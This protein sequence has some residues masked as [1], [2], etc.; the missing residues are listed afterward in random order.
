[1]AA[2]RPCNP[3]DFR[4]ITGVGDKKLEKYGAIFIGE[5]RRFSENQG[6]FSLPVNKRSSDSIT[7]EML[8][9]GMDLDE[10][11]SARN[12]SLNTIYGHIENLILAGENID[13]E[14]FITK[15]KIKAISN[16]IFEIGEGALKPIKDR[17]GDDFSYG[18]IK[19]VRAKVNYPR[20]KT[21]GMS[22]E[23]CEQLVDKEA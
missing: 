4:K 13:I 17:L 14:K 23:G 1:M 15:E 19:L 22:R 2:K 6:S 10:I 21:G 3:K 18:E 8:D 7:L 9:Q 5:I 11:T 20:L 12:L 16:A